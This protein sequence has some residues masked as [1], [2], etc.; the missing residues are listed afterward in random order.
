VPITSL[1]DWIA[2]RRR[3][4]SVPAIRGIDLLSLSRAEARIRLH[5][6]GSPDQ[7]KADLAAVDL[8]LDGGDP[9][10]RV[11]PASA[12]DPP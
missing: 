7:L 3:L 2:V 4:V 1:D 6:I 8:A 5:Y 9:V 12:A 11:R 10:W